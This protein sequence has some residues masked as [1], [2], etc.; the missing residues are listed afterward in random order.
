MAKPIVD[1]FSWNAP[2]NTLQ[3]LYEYYLGG[4]DEDTGGG[5]GGGTTG[6]YYP[7]STGGDNLQYDEMPVLSA[8]DYGLASNAMQLGYQP[9]DNQYY[10]DDI[11]EGTIAR[12]DLTLAESIVGDR[13]LKTI[14]KSDDE[15]NLDPEWLKKI[16]GS[17]L[18]KTVK[19]YA[20][21]LATQMMGGSMFGLPLAINQYMRPDATQSA[22]GIGGLYASEANRLEDLLQAGLLV[23]AGNQGIKS[24]TGKN[25]VSLMGGYEE[26]QQEIYDKLISQGYS[27]N[28]NGEVVDEDGNVIGGRTKKGKIHGNFKA[29]QFLEAHFNKNRTDIMT[30]N[31]IANMKSYTPPATQKDIWDVK[32]DKPSGD[33][34]VGVDAGTAN[35]QDYADIYEPS[36]SAT[37]SY[38]QPGPH[39]NGGSSDSGSSD[40]GSSS[41][42]MGSG[43]DDFKW[44]KGGLIRRPYAKGGI[45]DLL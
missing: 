27:M 9:V 31:T 17:P 34:P 11:G 10:L 42:S 16:K 24:I 41:D 43:M 2:G 45:V 19:P 22:V 6:A 38:S 44:A 36:A 13:G 1:M 40:S 5:G 39:G 15:E 23:D 29:K 14:R 26:G 25:V 37:T 3:A 35:I 7:Q 28:A 4:G 33:G 8:E 21:A 30:A 20:P 12:D 32:D 18:Y